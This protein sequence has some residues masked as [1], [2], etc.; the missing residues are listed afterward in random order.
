MRHSAWTSN[1]MGEPDPVP[2]E[3]TAGQTAEIVAAFIAA[4][5]AGVSHEEAGRQAAEANIDM[6]TIAVAESMLA[7]TDAAAASRHARQAQIAQRWGTAL[8]AYYVV[9][10]GAAELGALVA[11]PRPQAAL[12][13]MSKALVLLQARA[14]QTSFEVHAL[15]AAGFPGGAYGRYRT[16]HELAVIAALVSEYGR[17]PGHAHLADR[18]L[19]HAVIEQYRQ[20]GHRQRSGPGLGWPPLPAETMRELKQ[21]HDRLIRRYG[22]DYRAD[23]GWAAGLIEP[24]LT[25]A[26]LEAKADMGYLRY[27]YVTGSHL[28]HASAHGMTLTV[29]GQGDPASL[30]LTGPS[31]TGLAQP[32]QASLNTLIAVTGGLIEHGPAPGNP[33]S[34]LNFLALH[35]LRKRTITLLN[36]AEDRTPP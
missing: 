26:R 16:L 30:T 31:D 36:Q 20:A 17:Q 5:D 9:T 34:Y 6:L 10:Q 2:G 24:P 21:K 22:R 28:I 3:D 1:P 15:L 32:A 11:Q 18:F 25:F 12:D 35:E 29:P 4:I 14:C 13:S 19:G 7:K 23:Y 33:N 27:L 8:D